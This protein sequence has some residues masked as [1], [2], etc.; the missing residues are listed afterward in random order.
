[1]ATPVVDGKK[2][3]IRQPINKEKWSGA[4]KVVDCEGHI[5]FVLKGH[6]LYTIPFYLIDPDSKKSP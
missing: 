4:K 3:A 1:M 6:K 5:T 2:Q